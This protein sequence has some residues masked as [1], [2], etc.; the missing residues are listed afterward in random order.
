M[1]GMLMSAT[2]PSYRRM[3]KIRWSGLD[4]LSNPTIRQVRGG[5]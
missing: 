2:S 1:D 3:A 4:R 5:W